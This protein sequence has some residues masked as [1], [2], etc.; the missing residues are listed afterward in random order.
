MTLSEYERLVSDFGEPFTDKC[1]EVLDNYKGSSGRKYK[2]DYRAILNW[3]V[4]RV[5][6]QHSELVRRETTLISGNPF[7]QAR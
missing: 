5:K 2:S 4:D 6:E 3:V 7:R 1:I